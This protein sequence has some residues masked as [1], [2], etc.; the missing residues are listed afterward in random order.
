[1]MLVRELTCYRGPRT[2]QDLKPG[3][4][5]TAWWYRIPD[6]GRTPC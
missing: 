4:P 5:T 3:R 2:S 1:M 6:D